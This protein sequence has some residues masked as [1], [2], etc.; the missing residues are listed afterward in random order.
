MKRKIIII[1]S[2][3]LV[4]IITSLFIFFKLKS[5]KKIEDKIE[6]DKEIYEYEEGQ[7]NITKEYI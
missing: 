6:Y 2:I 5:D 3:I 4:V 7:K 1:A